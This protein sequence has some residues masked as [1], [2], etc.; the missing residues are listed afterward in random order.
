MNEI[1]LRFSRPVDLN[2]SSLSVGGVNVARYPVT[3]YR[4]DAG[5]HTATWTLA[6]PMNVDRVTFALDPG[7]GAVGA[8]GA[9][10]AIA[11]YPMRG[12]ADRNGLINIR[13][14]IEE[15]LRLGAT[16]G[17]P[18]AGRAPYYYY[19]DIDA[20]GRIGA[21]DMAA[22]WSN[23]GRKLP[24]NPAPASL[25]PPASPQET[26]TSAL[27]VPSVAEDLLR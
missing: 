6:F 5:T 10:P 21:T 26:A 12:N 23:L 19:Y 4:Y 22:T 1:T 25:P 13:D 20:D 7:A 24:P 11:L 15:R 17:R 9:F 18:S 16:T 27:S 3:G 2:E 8:G 14:F